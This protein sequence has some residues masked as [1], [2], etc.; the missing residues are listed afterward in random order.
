MRAS[1]V[2]AAASDE[3][4]NFAKGVVEAAP[5]ETRSDVVA[6]RTVPMPF[7]DQPPA[8]VRPSEAMGPQTTS[9][10][11]FVCS[12]LLPEHALVI[13]GNVK[14]PSTRAFPAKYALPVVVAPPCMVRPPDC[15]P[16]PMVVDERTKRPLAPVS[17]R[18]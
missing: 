10:V 1:V 14:V 12:A 2:V 6:S 16:L 11:T 17:Q 4:T 18:K 15:K 5:I 3:M 13:F 8:V 7:V 9:P